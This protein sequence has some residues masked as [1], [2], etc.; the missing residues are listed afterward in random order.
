MTVQELH[1]RMPAAELT[2]W[3]AFFELEPRGDERLDMHVA[4]LLHMYASVNA[5]RRRRFTVDDFMP[6][7]RWREEAATDVDEA[8]RLLAKFEEFEARRGKGARRKRGRTNR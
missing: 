6:Q 2:E 5:G 3:A 4:R 8:R 1:S 7:W